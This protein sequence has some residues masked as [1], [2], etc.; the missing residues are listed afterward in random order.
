[1]QINGGV[2]APLFK[3]IVATVPDKEERR[4]AQLH[5]EKWLSQRVGNDKPADRGELFVVPQ[6]CLALDGLVVPLAAENCLGYEGWNP[7]DYYNP[8]GE[9]EFRSDEKTHTYLFDVEGEKN[10]LSSY[11][12]GSAIIS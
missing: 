11:E 10:T 6:L 12:Y 7:L 5:A 4:H 3:K 9:D 8:I 1:L 2:D